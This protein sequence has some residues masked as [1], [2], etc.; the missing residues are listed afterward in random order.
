MTSP[1]ALSHDDT[2]LLMPTA[3]SDTGAV[4]CGALLVEAVPV[5]AEQLGGAPVRTGTPR[6]D[7]PAAGR[8]LTAGEGLTV[9]KGLALGPT[10]R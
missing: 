7:R 5:V 9:G 10:R 8:R 4:Q 6:L 2:V 1:P 3:A